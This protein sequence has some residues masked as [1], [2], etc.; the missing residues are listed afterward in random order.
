MA[1]RKGVRRIL[2][3]IN[4]E[5]K[6]TVKIAKITSIREATITFLAKVDIQR[7]NRAGE[8]FTCRDRE[9]MTKKHNAMQKYFEACFSDFIR[10]YNRNEFLPEENT[11][12]PNRI[13]LCWWQGIDKAP[14]VVR[15][16]VSSITRNAGNHPV[17]VITE[18]NYSEYIHLPEW[19][20]KKYTEGVISRTHF[21][22]ILRLSLLCKYGGLW[23]D[24][25]FYCTES[26]DKYFDSP[27]WSIKRPG[28]MNISVANGEFATYSLGC[29]NENR[30]VF[31]VI[32][33]LLLQYWKNNDFLV[34]YL[35]LDYFFVMAQ[36]IDTGIAD[37]FHEIQPNNSKC[38][39]LVRIINDPY[40]VEKWNELKKE[41]S[42]FKLTWKKDFL[43]SVNGTDTFFKKLS[44]NKHV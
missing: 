2:Y 34:D 23:M 29:N 8:T 25:T 39:D 20:L 30:W 44:N 43:L 35:M 31:G 16:C 17:V 4:E 36:K 22:D 7:L 12:Q 33:G 13:W 38:D 26:L 27:V 28:Y 6:A 10:N 32:L 40:D 18:Q 19:I 15:M 1:V 42:L 14:D 9:L 11:M 37:A 3:R 41:T 24:A 5:I 21:S